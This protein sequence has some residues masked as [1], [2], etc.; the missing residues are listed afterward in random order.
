MNLGTILTPALVVDILK[1]NIAFIKAGRCLP[2]HTYV[3]LSILSSRESMGTIFTSVLSQWHL[4]ATRLANIFSTFCNLSMSPFNPGYHTGPAYIIIGST[5]V[6]NSLAYMA[7]SVSTNDRN[8]QLARRVARSTTS[9]T[10]SVY[11]NLVDVMTPRSRMVSTLRRGNPSIVYTWCGFPWPKCRT[12]HFSIESSNTDL[13]SV[14]RSY[15][16]RIVV[17]TSL[18]SNQ[19]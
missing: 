12:A 9:V 17:P 7:G 11:F 16:E 14:L 6:E 1:S 10:C 4:K 19:L 2:I 8:I 18:S 13:Q 3:S 5:Y 15:L